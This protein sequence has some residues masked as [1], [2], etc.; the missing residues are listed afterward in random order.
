MGRG[1]QLFA[2]GIA[3]QV[4]D[5]KLMEEPLAGPGEVIKRVRGAWTSMLRRLVS[6]RLSPSRK[7]NPPQLVEGEAKKRS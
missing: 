2:Q 3:E 4:D 5:P 1:R 6:V 7:R